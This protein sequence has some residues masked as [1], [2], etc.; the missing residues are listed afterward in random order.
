MHSLVVYPFS[1]YGMYRYSTSSKVAL[2]KSKHSES[3]IEIANATHNL[4]DLT[5]AFV[6]ANVQAE[7]CKLLAATESSTIF[8]V[9][10]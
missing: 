7:L 6:R 8:L 9:H 4:Y 10:T 3:R 1:T 5:D 2:T